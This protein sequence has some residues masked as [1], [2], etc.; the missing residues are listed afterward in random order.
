MAKKNRASKKTQK[1]SQEEEFKHE[2]EYESPSTPQKS[3]SSHL[4]DSDQSW[5]QEGESGY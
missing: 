4:V 3:N 5:V 1:Q 2:E